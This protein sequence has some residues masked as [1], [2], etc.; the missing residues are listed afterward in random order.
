MKGRLQPI[1]LE[2]PISIIK[3]SP[4]K[5]PGQTYEQLYD[6]SNCL[7]IL[8]G[9]ADLEAVLRFLDENTYHAS[10]AET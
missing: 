10:K 3:K 4:L 9:D 1:F 8:Y 7:M 6:Y 2:E 5:N